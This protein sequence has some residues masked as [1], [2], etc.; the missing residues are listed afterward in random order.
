MPT[1]HE[2]S[3]ALSLAATETLRSARDAATEFAADLDEA[4][5]AIEQG[6]VLQSLG[7]AATFASAVEELGRLCTT[8]T[9]LLRAGSSLGGRS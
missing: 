3:Q 2:R 4:L 1:T 8:A 5:D 7:G 9:E 6:E